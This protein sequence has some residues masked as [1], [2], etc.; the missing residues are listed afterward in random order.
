M[1]VRVQISFHFSTASL[2]ADH[3]LLLL[4]KRYLLSLLSLVSTFPTSVTAASTSPHYVLPAP[5]FF[6]PSFPP[7]LIF[8]FFFFIYFFIF[9]SKSNLLPLPYFLFSLSLSIYYHDR[10][11]HAHR[12]IFNALSLLS[13]LLFTL[14]L[15]L[16][17][18]FSSLQ[19]YA[20]TN[21]RVFP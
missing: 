13:L 5:L 21:G 12:A 10:R 3:L 20:R 16:L 14:S 4:S 1:R 6:L 7:S 17:L 15:L 2:V 9:Y 19:A 18:L 11:T 8:L